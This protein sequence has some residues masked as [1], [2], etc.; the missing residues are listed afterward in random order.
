MASRNLHAAQL[1]AKCNFRLAFFVYNSL[2]VI[3][4]DGPAGAGKSSA[5]RLLAQ[6]LGYDYLD[7]GA[8]Y[9]AVTFASLRAKTNLG[10]Q[11][12]LTRLL[13]TL[14]IDLPPGCVLL[15]GEDITGLIRT[16]EITAASGPIADSPV[17]RR[18]LVDW[19]RRIAKD[20]NMVCE[21]RDQGT[22]VFPNALCKFFLVAEPAER[23]GRRH[24]ELVSRGEAVS[25]AD[26]RAAQEARDAR[27]AAR[28]IAPMVPA[29]DALVLDSTTL[30]LDEVV[31]RMEAEVK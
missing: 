7:T 14:T 23:A 29:K 5:A 28:D 6:R 26:V 8:M 12:A 4:I 31:D 20:R 27:D 30:A 9:R 2:M 1:R 15:N 3:T 13:D 25:L 24:R 11:A 10:D 17:V 19:Q 21:G 16:P 22:S 18:R